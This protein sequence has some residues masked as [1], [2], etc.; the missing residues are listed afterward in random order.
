[1]K[2]EEFPGLLKEALELQDTDLQVS[3]DLTKIEAYDSMAVMS[4]IAFVDEHFSKRL[5]AK[6]LATITTVG[7]LMELIG[8]ENFTD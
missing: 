6:Q 1:M 2:K 5:T 7:N 3:T 8:M 4:V